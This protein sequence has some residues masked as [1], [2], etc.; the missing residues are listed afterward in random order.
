MQTISVEADSQDFFC[1][2]TGVQLSGDKVVNISEEVFANTS[3]VALLVDELGLEPVWARPKFAE[4]IAAIETAQD[5]DEDDGD[6]LHIVEALD[7]MDLADNFVLFEVKTHGFA[8]GPVS[9]VT[10]FLI[11]FSFEP[12]PAEG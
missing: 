1:P 5:D 9:T 6:W 12:I 2:V 11:D 8:C 4:A 3:L 10:Y 7:K